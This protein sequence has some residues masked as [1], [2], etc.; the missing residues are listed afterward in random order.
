MVEAFSRLLR[1]FGDRIV[2][3]GECV[4]RVKQTA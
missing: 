4:R 2:P 3:V 1:G